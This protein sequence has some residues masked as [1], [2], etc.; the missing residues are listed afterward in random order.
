[1]K[2]YLGTHKIHWLG[3][4][5]VPLFVSHRQARRKVKPI[6][7]T[8]TW[9]LDSGG[10]TELS[11]YGEWRT[12][13]NEYVDAVARYMEWGGLE[14]AAQQD[15]MCE[16]QVLEKT[17]KSIPEHQE[18]TVQNYL[19]L[20]ATRLPFKASLQGETLDDYLRHIE[21]FASA[22]VDLTT[23]DLVAVG[24]VCRRTGTKEAERIFRELAALGLKMHG[25]GVKI[26]GLR[27]YADA[28]ASTD[29][30]AWSFRARRKARDVQ[31]AGGVYRCPWGGTHRYCAN[32]LDFALD[33]RAQVLDSFDL[34]R[35]VL[36][37]R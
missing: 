24:S 7:A 36:L 8:T 25:F 13:L 3:Q 34:D 37:E 20:A 4:V 18:L 22:G 9:A 23:H 30:L 19:D 17:G 31:A 21:M 2:F 28:L 26:T 27:R 35:G 32:C 11:T 33:W 14:W 12:S 29:S 6:R 15:W 1:M 10:F 5:D 16:P